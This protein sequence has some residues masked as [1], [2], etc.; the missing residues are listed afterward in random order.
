WLPAHLFWAYFFGA[1]YIA[2]GV[3]IL[4][5]VVARLAAALSALQMGIF[6]LLV[7]VPMVLAGHVSAGNWSE[8]VISW[9][10]TSGGWMVADSY[11]GTSWSAANKPWRVI[12]RKARSL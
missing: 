6:T 11:R 7:W 5:G 9:T 3:A 2:A 4:I 8:L 12:G 10:L 1:T